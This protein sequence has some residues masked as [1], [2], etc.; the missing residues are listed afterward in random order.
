MKQTNRLTA[1]DIVWPNVLYSQMHY[2]YA[3]CKEL[4]MQETTTKRNIK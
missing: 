3:S 1:R 4:G 2:V